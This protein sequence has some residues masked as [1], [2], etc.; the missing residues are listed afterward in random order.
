MI[1][2]FDYHC[3]GESHK[4][5]NKVCQDYSYSAIFDDYGLAIVCDG[6]GGKRYFRSDIGARLATEIS[7]QNIKQFVQGIDPSLFNGKSY[8][9]VEALTTEIKN[10]NVRKFGSIDKALRQL[11]GSILVQWQCAIRAHA[12]SNPITDCEK[13]TVEQKYLD[14]FAKGETLEKIYGCTLMA[15]LRTSTYWI[16]FHLGDGK[17]VAIDADGV[18]KEPIPWD[19][20]CFLNKTTSICDTDAINEFRYCYCGDGSFPVAVFLGSDGMD[21]S[22]GEEN[23]LANFYLQVAKSIAQ[24][25]NDAVV[26]DVQATLPILSKRGS[27]DDMSIAC[28]YDERVVDILPKIIE[29]QLEFN[30]A[31]IRNINARIKS[32]WDRI[33]KLP[34]RGLPSEKHAIELNYAEQDINKGYEAKLA[35]E[36]VVDKLNRELYGVNAKAYRDELGHSK[37]CL[38][39][40]L[41]SACIRND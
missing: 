13:S 16:G 26:K 7:A 20:R 24:E 41:K 33:S 28:V 34:Y 4:A 23:N 27:Q 12:E 31:K 15:Y 8:T 18:W 22:F 37:Q 36:K 21:D 5:I 6:H 17:C 25:G 30:K 40:G 35:Q 14:E 29:W 10:Q 1:R 2:C 38:S 39:C 9:A 19:E 11:F 3:Q 32:A